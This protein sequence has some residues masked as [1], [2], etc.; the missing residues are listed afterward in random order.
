VV[1]GSSDSSFHLG[2]V[3]INVEAKFHT[4]TRSTQ[5]IIVEYVRLRTESHQLK[6]PPSSEDQVNL[7]MGGIAHE[8]IQFTVEAAGIGIQTRLLAT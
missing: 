3:E 4:Q 2:R 7:I 6:I 5:I 1:P 8:N